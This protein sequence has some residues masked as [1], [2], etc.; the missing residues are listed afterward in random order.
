M[1]VGYM[2]IPHTLY[3]N[4]SICRFWHP[5]GS[6]NQS[7]KMTEGALHGRRGMWNWSAC[8][9]SFTSDRPVTRHRLFAA[10]DCNCPVTQTMPIPP[11]CPCFPANS[12]FDAL[13]YLSYF[14]LYQEQILYELSITDCSAK[15]KIYNFYSAV[16]SV[17]WDHLRMKT[18]D[19]WFVPSQY[20]Y[21]NSL[22]VY[23]ALSCINLSLT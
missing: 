9:N 8:S 4:L 14:K 1:C 12:S 7:P 10:A 22:E 16:L 6:W 5:P 23:H 19:I 17:V 20:S 15:L 11:A 18:C 21:S 2:Q 13:S 3:N